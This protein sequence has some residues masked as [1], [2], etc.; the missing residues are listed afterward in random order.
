[1][2]LRYLGRSTKKMPRRLSGRSCKEAR[3]SLSIPSI[4]YEAF[5]AVAM[6]EHFPDLPI[7]SM[8]YQRSSGS[9]VDSPSSLARPSLTNSLLFWAFM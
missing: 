4:Q 9:L 2:A 3:Q 8:N 5:V 7:D 1:M 6:S